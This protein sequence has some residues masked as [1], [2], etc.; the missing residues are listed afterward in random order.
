ML[1]FLHISR[2]FVSSA[3]RND[4]FKEVFQ[5]HMFDMTLLKG[6]NCVAVM[7]AGAQN[8]RSESAEKMSVTIQSIFIH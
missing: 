5:F 8:E 3:C 4:L 2:G 1:P 6:G 7:G